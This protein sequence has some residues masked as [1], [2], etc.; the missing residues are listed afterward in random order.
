M[1]NL[2]YLCVLSLALFITACGNKTQGNTDVDSTKTDSTKIEAEV[3]NLTIA[4]GELGLFELT[5]PVKSCKIKTKWGT[6][7]RTF[8]ENGMWLTHEGKP[9]SKVYPN[10]I[11]RDD[12]GRIIQGL[13]DADGN[14]D[15]YEY[16]TDGNRKRYFFHYGDESTEEL[17]NY[18]ADGKLASVKRTVIS[19][20]TDGEPI[21]ETYEILSTD[22][23][24]NW[25]KRKVIEG[26]VVDDTQT[27]T[28]TYFE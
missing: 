26:K 24:G 17:N 7:T 8:D 13:M 18:D 15:D 10:G 23:H 14:G 6:I 20:D 11:K 21:T 22:D 16:N 19:F 28:I 3:E 2:F 12:Q 25:T 4:K 5:G 1:K 9:L 27:R